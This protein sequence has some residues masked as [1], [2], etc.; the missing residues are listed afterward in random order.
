MVCV[1]LETCGQYFDRG[2]NKKKLDYFLQY[3][4]VS[5]ILTKSKRVFEIKVY[6]FIQR[7][8]WFKKSQPIW[9]Q[10]VSSEG[11]DC[12][13]HSEQEEKK[14]NCLQFPVQINYLVQ[15]TIE[16]LRP[17]MK[18]ASSMEEATKAVQEV[19]KEILSKLGTWTIVD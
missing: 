7:Y 4:Q 19:E 9:S 6:F 14:E 3:F 1:L 12:E 17:K 16:L 11:E 15:D 5:L 18:L 10:P 13:G 2:T 8:I